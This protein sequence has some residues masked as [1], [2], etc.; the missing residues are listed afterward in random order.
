MSESTNPSSTSIGQFINL[1]DTNDASCLP[2]GYGRDVWSAT[3]SPGIYCPSGYEIAA[4]GT[5]V[6]SAVWEKGLSRSPEERSVVCCLRYVCSFMHIP[7]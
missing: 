4:T 2:P 3:F 6:Y 7:L 5:E 1:L